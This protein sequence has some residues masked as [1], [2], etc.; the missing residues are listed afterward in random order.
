MNEA[1]RKTRACTIDTLDDELKS[2]IRGHGMKYGL[3][4]LESHILI[5]C[6]TIT[7]QQ[8]K[9]YID[10]NKDVT[11]IVLEAKAYKLLDSE[12]ISL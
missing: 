9:G 4:E 11:F 1:S 3:E 6:E 10:K 2:A 12:L 8:K 5:C 7:V